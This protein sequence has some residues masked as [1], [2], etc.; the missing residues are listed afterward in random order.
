MN[1]KFIYDLTISLLASLILYIPQLLL[2]ISTTNRSLYDIIVVALVILAITGLARLKK[3]A[4][5]KQ[6]NFM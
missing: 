6:K 1:K 3:H 4:L 2:D 5:A